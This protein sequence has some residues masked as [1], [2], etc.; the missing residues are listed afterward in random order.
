MMDESD[1]DEAYSVW[2]EDPDLRTLHSRHLSAVHSEFRLFLTTRVGSG[3][4][5][6]A[7]LIQRGLKLA[8]ESKS[9]GRTTV[10]QAFEVQACDIQS[11]TSY[12][13]KP[14]TGENTIKV[15]PNR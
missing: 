6:P 7:V 8:C 9:D 12:W 4:P 15:L 5:L 1:E 10:K 3:R 2:T 13:K 14:F 11:W